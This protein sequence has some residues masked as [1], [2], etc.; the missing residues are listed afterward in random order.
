MTSKE[1]RF[2]DR[3]VLRHYPKT[4]FF[5]PLG[6]LSIIL[7]IAEIVFIDTNARPEAAALFA[8]LWLTIFTFNF[9]II[10]FEFS[11]GKT[12]GIV[13]G[14]ALIYVLAIVLWGLDFN[15][16]FPVGTVD[17]AFYIWTGI[18]IVFILGVSIII[19]YFN[20]WEIRSTEIYWK[21]GFFE[22]SKRLGNA[23]HAHIYKETPDIFERILFRSGT[24]V[25]IPDGSKIVYK[26][27]NVYNA[28]GK[29]K[30]IREILSYV[31]DRPST[32][33]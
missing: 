21:A 24:I 6:I 2:E 30:K 28:S 3:V 5:Y 14:I 33:D 22:D 18:V 20:Y 17:P 26:L 13:M 31:P 1:T 23:Q 25:I 7:G 4:I 19:S 16:T 12:A 8:S 27:E 11:I 32:V 10:S 15:L 29:E 9:L